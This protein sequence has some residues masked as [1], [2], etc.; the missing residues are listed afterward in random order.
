MDFLDKVRA[1]FGLDKKMDLA[2]RLG[3]TDPRQYYSLERATESIR[4][5][6]LIAL[7]RLEGMTDK[8]LLDLI[9]EELLVVERRYRRPPRKQPC[10]N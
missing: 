10:K 6:D 8:L 2:R 5:K 1:L 7:R 4:L 9:E 3:F